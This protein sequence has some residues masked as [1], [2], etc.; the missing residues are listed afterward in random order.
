MPLLEGT[1]TLMIE[2]QALTT[3]SYYNMPRRVSS[4]IDFNRLNMIIAILEKKCNM[5]LGTQD[6][7]VNVVGGIKVTETASDLAV[8]MSMV[9]SFKDICVPADSIFVGELSLTGEIRS[10]VNIEK[11]V[12]EAAKLGFKKFYG[13]KGQLD[14]LKQEGKIKDMMLISV[15]NINDL[16]LAALNSK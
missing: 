1:S 16:I 3:H 9:S 6:I 15:K 12:K 5:N 7:Y 13:P 10:V 8:A 14:K 4:G 11:R 2:I